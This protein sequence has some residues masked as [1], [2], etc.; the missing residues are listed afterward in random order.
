MP[1]NRYSIDVYILTQT[2]VQKNGIG[3]LG[4][5]NVYTYEQYYSSEYM[6]GSHVTGSLGLTANNQPTV[7]AVKV[8]RSYT[9]NDVSDLFNLQGEAGVNFSSVDK[10]VPYVIFDKPTDS[11]FLI[12]PMFYF[13]PL[14]SN[15]ELESVTPESSYSGEAWDL[16]SPSIST[17]KTGYVFG[18]AVS[19]SAEVPG[20]GGSAGLLAG[21]ANANRIDV[22]KVSLESSLFDHTK[23]KLEYHKDVYYDNNS[24]VIAKQIYNVDTAGA[25][26]DD[27]L[28][29]IDANVYA[30]K[31]ST[32]N[33]DL[34][35]GNNTD[36]K[37]ALLVGL[38]NSGNLLNKPAASMFDGEVPNWRMI[39]PCGLITDIEKMSPIDLNGGHIMFGSTLER[40]GSNGSN[41]GRS[42]TLGVGAAVVNQLYV[43][44]DKIGV[45][46]QMIQGDGRLLMN[47]KSYTPSP[48]ENVF[49][50]S[51]YE[52]SDGNFHQT[53]LSI[54]GFTYQGNS[55]FVLGT[56]HQVL[57][58]SIVFNNRDKLKHLGSPRMPVVSIDVHSG[59]IDPLVLGSFFK[60][61]FTFVFLDGTE[62]PLSQPSE[63]IEIPV[64][65]AQL[66]VIVSQANN[67]NERGEILFV[68]N[69]I[70]AIRIYRAQKDNEAAEFSD[71]IVVAD[72]QRD[73]SDDFYFKPLPGPQPYALNT[74]EDSV[75]NL[76]YNPYTK[77][78]AI[79]YP[80]ADILV[81]K[82]R[83]VLINNASLEN[84][85]V[86]QY[87]DVDLAQA[88]PPQNLR[89]IQ[90]GDGDTLVAGFSLNNICYLFKRKKTY[91]IHGDVASG[92]LLD[93]DLNVGTNFRDTIASFENIIY[94]LNNDGIYK[95]EE[96]KIIKLSIDRLDVYFDKGL[97]DSIDFENLGRNCFAHVNKLKR[98]IMFYVPRLKGDGTAQN[99][100]NFV[101]VYDVDLDAFRTYSHFDP[102]F[103]AHNAND[104]LDKSSIELLGSYGGKVF[105]T[106]LLK[107]DNGKAIPYSLRTKSFNDNSNFLNKKFNFIRIFGKYLN[108]LYITY[109]IDGERKRGNLVTRKSSTVRDEGTI[110]VTGPPNANEIVIEVSGEDAN[111]APIEIEEIL[112]GYD[113]YKGVQR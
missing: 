56:F 99:E 69:T 85:N 111:E 17:M 113:V 25:D 96:A 47:R 7:G 87:S 49:V 62:S 70:S 63:T 44:T 66:K 41:Y 80:V 4:I 35:N 58:K 110:Y 77:S 91:G 101:I 26:E 29:R 100:N 3:Q 27:H 107:N 40:V 36:S 104:I 55:N 34:F 60:Y 28:I 54:N 94:F 46:K 32:F 43:S 18:N 72:I 12:M 84:N 57:D 108:T 95:I 14:I 51:S 82:N 92:V 64:A 75:Q 88:I 61:Y 53:D 71:L 42:L 76:S 86:I 112:L 37:Y 2:G 15:A 97:N 39:V 98:I 79:S 1:S 22:V 68:A 83:L 48:V 73:P 8:T 109:W 23:L 19:L 50:S 5:R 21:T 13:S 33:A 52:L 81:H 103:T 6:S 45:K 20:L 74:Y 67:L 11:D 78:N 16:A 9:S 31:D 89:A 30:L 38:D 93:I 65:A 24:T 10:Q 59:A 105:M 106:T 102:I 90:S